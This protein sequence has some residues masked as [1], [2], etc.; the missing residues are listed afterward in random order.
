MD[1]VGE[2]LRYVGSGLLVK[3]RCWSL[4]RGGEVFIA[5]PGPDELPVSPG[6][7]A[8]YLVH[9]L[10]AQRQ[11]YRAIRILMAL[12]GWRRR[13]AI[14]PLEWFECWSTLMYTSDINKSSVLGSICCSY[15]SSGH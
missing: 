2:L 7:A 6:Y 14:P 15:S 12:L 1:G 5:L 10:D 9:E 11:V 3:A 4:R 8:S 13:R